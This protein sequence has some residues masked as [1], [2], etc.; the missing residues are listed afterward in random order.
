FSFC[1]SHISL[2]NIVDHLSEMVLGAPHGRATTDNSS[3]Y[4]VD[5]LLIGFGTTSRLGSLFARLPRMRDCPS[6]RTTILER[7][8]STLFSFSRSTDQSYQ[9]PKSLFSSSSLKVLETAKQADSPCRL[10]WISQLP[11]GLDC[12]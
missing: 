10:S 12:L 7:I 5:H 1:A 6:F 3:C 2:S 11:W 9:S 8:V 4:C